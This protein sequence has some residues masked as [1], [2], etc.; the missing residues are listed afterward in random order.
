MKNNKAATD[1]LNSI[2]RELGTNRED[3]IEL[4]IKMLG[5]EGLTARQAVDFILGDGAYDRLLLTR[6]EA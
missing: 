3:T 1:L 4:A 2:A 5:S 6:I